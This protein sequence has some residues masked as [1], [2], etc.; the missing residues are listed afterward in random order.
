[1]LESFK[2]FNLNAINYFIYTL[3]SNFWF[4]LII[5]GLIG[6]IILMLKEEIDT[7]IREEQ[8]II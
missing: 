7:A 6:T 5:I 2:A 3:T 4:F 1:M 8:N